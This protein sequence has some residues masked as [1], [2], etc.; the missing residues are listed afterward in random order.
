MSRTF[1]GGVVRGIL[2]STRTGIEA[3]VSGPADAEQH[4]YSLLSPGVGP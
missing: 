2:G 1:D 3:V 4:G